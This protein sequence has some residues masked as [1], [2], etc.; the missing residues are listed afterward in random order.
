MKLSK[1]EV[2][3]SFGA[4][5]KMAHRYLSLLFVGLASLAASASPDRA[6]SPNGTKFGKAAGAN[7]K[8]WQISTN[9][10]DGMTGP[11]QLTNA[12]T[13]ASNYQ[14]IVVQ[15]GVYDLT[16][17][18]MSVDT[19]TKDGQ[20]RAVTN[21]LSTLKENRAVDADLWIAL[22]GDTDGKWDDKV[23]FKGDGRCIDM[24]QWT[25]DIVQNITFEGFDAGDAAS[26]SYVS[27]GGAVKAMDNCSQNHAMSNCVFRNCRASVGGAIS[28]GALMECLVTNCVAGSTGGVSYNTWV[29]NSLLV[30]NVSAGRGG[31]MGS[32]QRCMGNT[33]LR[34]RANIAGAVDANNGLKIT[35]NTFVGNVSLMEAGAVCCRS[36]VI[37][38]CTFVG[39]VASNSHGG[40]VYFAAQTTG[41]FGV[42][43]CAFVSN[44]V[45][46]ISKTSHN[47]GAAFC[48]KTVPFVNCGF[49]NNY[50][51]SGGGAVHHGACTNCTFVGNRALYY[52]AALYGQY[53]N[54][55]TG[56]E[57]Y[58]AEAYNCVFRDN[59]R[60]DNTG[61]YTSEHTEYGGNDGFGAK[62]VNCD[63]NVGGYWRCQVVNTR[64]HHVTNDNC[65]GVFYEQNFVTNC[66]V[67]HCNL[68][69]SSHG[70]LQR[71]LYGPDQQNI[72]YRGRDCGTFVNCTFA[73]NV[74]HNTSGFISSYNGR[75][76]L[77]HFANCIFWNNRKADGTEADISGYNQMFDI[78]Y[79]NCLVGASDGTLAYNGVNSWQDLGGNVFGVDPKFAADRAV[80]LGVDHYAL[81]CGSPARGKG[82]VAAIVGVDTDLAGRDRLRD[83]KLDLG[84]YQ[85]WLDP[86]GMCL[87]FR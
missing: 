81:R 15:P 85:C 71:Y 5:A 82:D 2:G 66:L 52:G 86:V 53:S 3:V 14:M 34:N 74:L 21:H 16:G 30:D 28:G 70:L 39:N 50:A 63:S 58:P 24:R 32:A 72:W 1:S 51:W 6:V 27:R 4:L 61:R 43:N 12:F 79:T 59:L 75:T 46:S 31:A 38:D 29:E 56:N 17:L 44:C 8:I 22:V 11:Q 68:T 26:D 87:F 13:Q 76:N 69:K 62:I 20:T 57:P 64:I 19:Y 41:L 47:G 25:V 49:T 40:A 23:V 37:C 80:K 60:R 73:D 84:C 78:A 9:V 18:A 65:S 7:T 55:N 10:V 83:G 35:N 45:Y 36:N 48:D 77:Q 33:F 42:Y 54:N 67:D